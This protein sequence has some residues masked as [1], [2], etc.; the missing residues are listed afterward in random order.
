M[1]GPKNIW[2]NGKVTEKLQ[3]NISNLG[4][5]LVGRGCP[6]LVQNILYEFVYHINPL[7]ISQLPYVT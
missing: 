1:G 3:T 2:C 5:V 4:E 7:W 6:P